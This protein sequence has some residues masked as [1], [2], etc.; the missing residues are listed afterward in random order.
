MVIANEEDSSQ[1]LVE[2]EGLGGG[3]VQG[4][5]EVKDF[6]CWNCSGVEQDPVAK[7]MMCSVEEVRAALGKGGFDLEK[8][9]PR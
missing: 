1:M 8:F 5:K 2:E 7:L 4:P 3:R 6:P 9:D